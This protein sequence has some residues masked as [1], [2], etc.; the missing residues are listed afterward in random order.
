MEIA[1]PLKV[2][3]LMLITGKGLIVCKHA[4]DYCRERPDCN[5]VGYIMAK[6][7]EEANPDT[8]EAD[9]AMFSEAIKDHFWY[10][11]WN[12][13]LETGTILE[14]DSPPE[15]EPEPIQEELPKFSCFKPISSDD[16]NDQ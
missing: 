8:G 4:V 2:R 14:E 13:F 10:K 11:A 16:G 3:F 12:Q 6:D 1:D 15:V 5:E 7:Y 9:V